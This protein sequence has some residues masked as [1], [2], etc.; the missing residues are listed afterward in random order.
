VGPRT[1]LDAVVRRTNPRPGR[2]SNLG[3]PARSLVTVLIV[4][5]SPL[6]AYRIEKA[7]LN[8]R[9]NRTVGELVEKKWLF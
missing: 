8:K 9:I 7:L 2:K 6:V 4:L 3:R 1:S 5:G